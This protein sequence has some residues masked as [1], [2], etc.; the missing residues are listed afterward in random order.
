MALAITTF[1]LTA[2]I[3]LLPVGITSNHT[4]VEQSAAAN[5]VRDVLSD[6]RG[7]PAASGTSSIYN[8]PIPSAGTASTINS[9]QPQT[10]FFF[11]A[12]TCTIGQT[13]TSGTIPLLYRVTIGFAPPAS[14]QH[15]ATM[16]RVLIT[17]PALA[18]Q[19]TTA[20]PKNYS[21]SYESTTALDRN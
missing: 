6:L 4:S 10:S 8:I 11:A 16:A 3:G 14:G 1:C 17:W 21:G 5:I 2:L 13:A 12:D 7:T 9:L 19:T 20:W 15:T 18:D